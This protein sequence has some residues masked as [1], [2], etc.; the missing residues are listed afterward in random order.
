MDK[1]A[2]I[3]MV[4][5]NR[6]ELTKQTLESLIKTAEYPINLIIVDNN[7]LDGTVKW[8]KDFV[9]AHHD[10]LVGFKLI[11]NDENRGIAYGRNQCLKA[12]SADWLV[13]LDN[14]VILPQGWLK[15]CIELLE[16]NKDFGAIGVNFEKHN[17]KMIER[18]GKMFQE[19]LKGNIGSATMVFNRSIHK[20]LGFFDS[21]KF[22]GHEDS[23][24]GCRVRMLGLKLGYL[25]ENGIHLGEGQN[26]VG[27][28]RE[29]KNK[30]GQ[31]NLVIHNNLYNDYVLRKKSLF[32][33]FKE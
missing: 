29:F 23:L 24:W 2:D 10:A 16:E 15:E 6:L 3:M 13:T 25:K 19:K 18:N 14:D 8:I 27:E 21:L 9:T 11:L 7:S 31:E 22:Y 30:Y 4:T 33:S 5:Y 20:M 26:D 32:V 17:F 28:Y 12:S 1:K